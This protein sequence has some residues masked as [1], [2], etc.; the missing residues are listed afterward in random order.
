MKKIYSLLALVI[1]FVAGASVVQAQKRY[2]FEGGSLGAAVPWTYDGV[3]TGQPFV[4]QSGV[5]L[6]GEADV[7]SVSGN[8]TSKL[9]DDNIFVLEQE[10]ESNADGYPVYVLKHQATGQYLASGTVA[11]TDTKSRAWRFCVKEPIQWTTDQIN[12]VHSEETPCEIE[13]WTTATTVGDGARNQLLLVDAAGVADTTKTKKSGARFLYSLG[14]G[15]GAGFGANYTNN[16]WELFSVVELT[17]AAYVQECMDEIF[18]FIE[19]EEYPYNIFNV[20]TEPGQ[21]SQT[22]WDELKASYEHMDQLIANNETD[23]AVCEAAVQR[24][25]AAVQAAKD[26]AVKVKEGYYF[27]NGRRTDGNCTWE[28]DGLRWNYEHDANGNEGGTW[29]RPEVLD[30]PNAKYVWQLIEDKANPGAY[31]IQSFWT[32]RYIGVPSD[33]GVPVPTTEEAK[34]SYLIYPQNKDYFVIQSTYLKENPIMGWNGEELS[35]LHQAGDHDGVVA[36]TADAIWSGWTFL[37]VSQAEI[38]ALADQIAQAQLNDDAAALLATAQASYEKGFYYTNYIKGVDNVWSNAADQT[39]GPIEATVDGNP[40]NLF[41]TDWHGVVT[42]QF[43]YFGADLGEAV[44]KIQLSIVARWKGGQGVTDAPSLVQ[45]WGSNVDPRNGDGTLNEEV[46]IE[47][48][49]CLTNEAG[50]ENALVYDQAVS[51]QG[52]TKSNW[53]AQKIYTFDQPYRYIKMEPRRR[54]TTDLSAGSFWSCS[55]IEMTGTDLQEGMITAIPANI[56][57][58]FE[59]AMATIKAELEAESATQA[60]ID[61]LQAAYDAFLD[62]YPDPSIAK[63]AVKAAQTQHDNAEENAT[64]YAYYQPGAKAELQAVINAQTAN[65]KD[66]MT[67]EE[68]KA[69]VKAIDD[70]LVVFASKLNVPANGTLVFLRS[71]TTDERETAAGQAY[72]MVSGNSARMKWMKAEGVDLSVYPQVAWKFIHA[73]DGYRLQNMATGEYMDNPK[74]NNVGVFSSTVADTCSF[75]LQTPQAGFFNIVFAKNVFANAQPGYNNLVTWNAAEGLDNSAFSFQN[76]PED[77]TYEGFYSWPVTANQM[78]ILTLPFTID[79]MANE[80]CYSVVGCN[81]NKLILKTLSGEIAAG[82]P[83]FFNEVDGATTYEFATQAASFEELAQEWGAEAKEANGLQ[84]TLAPIA[85]LPSKFG[86]LYQ[87]TTIVNP[88]EGEGVGNN[89]GYIL[90]N[91]AATTET[92]DAQ[93]NIDA[94]LTGINEVINVQNGV[95]NVYSIDGIKVRANVKSASDLQGLPA[96]IYIMGNRK[97]LVK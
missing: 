48:P 19:G 45:L 38:D 92:G 21:I 30:L 15:K 64:E 82:T 58:A 77:F 87:G 67:L 75:Q 36:W 68:V 57:S 2:T 61:A 47:I 88:E 18:P 70:A 94:D 33:K 10:T 8:K 46:W 86:I 76:V 69:V 72:V 23:Q 65:L 4:L 39:E 14:R 27:F 96:G 37:N 7:F 43:H 50:E 25:I 42:D 3:Q 93:I 71:E 56:R 95:V 9:T 91:I 51:Y 84:G 41:H 5:E 49:N 80:G 35:C 53:M 54:G 31:F 16:T 90:T 1:L 79:V 32:K 83:F 81:D 6:G 40:T 62:V 89:S 66:V 63:D 17:G 74:K 85:E 29:V 20:G 24:A 55:E 13:D 97:I 12:V 59:N 60:S 22:L 11:F 44:D 26:G 34:Y 52:T 78:Q 28:D 73:A